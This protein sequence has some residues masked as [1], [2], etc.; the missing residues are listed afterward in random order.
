MVGKDGMLG[1]GVG[2]R[3]VGVLLNLCKQWSP[4]TIF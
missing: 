3:D 1:G 4:N 2:G